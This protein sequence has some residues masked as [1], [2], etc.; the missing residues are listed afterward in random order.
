MRR[1]L[2]EDDQRKAADAIAEHLQRTNW[3]IERGPPA[4]R[5]GPHLM[6]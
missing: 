4:E 1:L 6:P 2:T 3:K 5:H